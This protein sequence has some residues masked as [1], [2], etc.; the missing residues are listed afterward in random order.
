MTATTATMTAHRSLAKTLARPLD[1]LSLSARP[2]K[3]M[4]SHLLV[5]EA[6][7]ELN[8]CDNGNQS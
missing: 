8:V 3:R 1:S 5:L 4:R 7:S 2:I 6:S